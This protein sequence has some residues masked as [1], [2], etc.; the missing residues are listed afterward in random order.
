MGGNWKTYKV[1][2][3]G[4]TSITDAQMAA[5]AGADYL[6]VLVDVPGSERSLTINQA[7]AIAESSQIPVVVLLSGKGVEDIVSV[8]EILRP[9]AVHLLGRMP[10]QVIRDLKERLD[11]QVWQTVYLP[12]R[13]QAEV[14]VD[15]LTE[16]MRGYEH[17]G[18]DVIV[19]DIMSLA[20]NGTVRRYG[21]VMMSRTAYTRLTRLPAR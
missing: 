4:T 19:V 1:K 20:A 12:V 16:L 14:D 2:I 5:D 11:C 21:T 18:A 8:V 13:G 17:A 15:A 7:L 9:F 3:C 10:Y 6:G